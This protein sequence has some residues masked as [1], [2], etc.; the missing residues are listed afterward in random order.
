MSLDLTNL[1][2][3]IRF[4]CIDKT[5]KTLERKFIEKIELE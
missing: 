5:H 1:K 2:M 4:F 3:E